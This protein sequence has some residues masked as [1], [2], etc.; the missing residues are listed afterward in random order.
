MN[1]RGIIYKYQQIFVYNIF[2]TKIKMHAGLIFHCGISDGVG[3][4]V[5]VI[6][7]LRCDSEN[8]IR[9]RVRFKRCLKD[10]FPVNKHRMQ[11]LLVNNHWMNG[12]PFEFTTNNK[13]TFCDLWLVCTKHLPHLWS[14]KLIRQCYG[15]AGVFF[16]IE[17]VRDVL[18]FFSG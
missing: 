3:D 6:L 5:G 12:R 18:S 10:I 2:L 13:K 1:R 7:D 17:V 16:E 4:G 14:W 15:N 8:F 11:E 9:Y